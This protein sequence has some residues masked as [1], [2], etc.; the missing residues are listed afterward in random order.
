MGEVFAKAQRALGPTA[1]IDGGKEG[2][3]NEEE[4]EEEGEARRVAVAGCWWVYLDWLMETG[5][6]DKKSKGKDDTSSSSE[7]DSDDEEEDEEVVRKEKGKKAVS[8][9]VAKA[10]EHALVSTRGPGRVALCRLWHRCLGQK[11]L[12][13]ALSYM[14]EG[15]AEEREEMAALCLEAMEGGKEEGGYTV[16]WFEAALMVCGKAGTEEAAALW[17]AYETFERGQGRHQAANNVRWRRGKA[18]GEK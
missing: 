14:G 13:Q 8:P 1:G 5:G 12:Q 10:L 16:A 2:G 18:M 17:E 11:G 9:K 15:R 4:E 3:G 6:E 7:S